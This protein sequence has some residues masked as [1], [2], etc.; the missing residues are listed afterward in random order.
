MA[1]LTSLFLRIL[2]NVPTSTIDMEFN[3]NDERKY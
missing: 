1:T 2:I 3:E